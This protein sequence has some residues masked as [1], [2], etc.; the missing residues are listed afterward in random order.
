M[1]SICT[2]WTTTTSSML[3]ASRPTVTGSALPMDHPSRSG[4]WHAR[5]WSRNCARESLP[6][7]HR[8][9]TH[10]SACHWPGRLTD[11]PCSPATAT[12][13]FASGKSQSQLVKLTKIDDCSSAF[14]SR[15]CKSSFH[16][17]KKM[18]E[19]SPKVEV[20]LNL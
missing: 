7:T 13:R 12:T 9:P 20:F 8:R 6:T 11:R 17:N 16:L 10:H 19:N 18:K 3:C 4:I 5:K 15:K 2:P 14:R 1:A